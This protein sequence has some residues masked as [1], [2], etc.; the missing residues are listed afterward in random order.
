M[1]MACIAWDGYTF[2]PNSPVLLEPITFNHNSRFE[3]VLR[4]GVRLSRPRLLHSVRCDTSSED[5]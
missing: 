4:C 5:T 1:G 3:F 2:I